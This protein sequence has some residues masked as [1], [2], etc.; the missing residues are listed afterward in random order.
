MKNK[1]NIIFLLVMAAVIITV[2]VSEFL[3]DRPDRS[4]PNP[5][6]YDVEEFKNVDP[7]LIL[8]KESK[9]FKIGFEE[10]AAIAV[11]NE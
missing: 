3:S 9:N 11:H 6:A 8:Y 5:F 7:E 2:I 1:G 4:K 10:P